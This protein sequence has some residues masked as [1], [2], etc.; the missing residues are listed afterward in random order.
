MYLRGREISVREVK[1]G[2]EP[3][4]IRYISP[5]ELKAGLCSLMKASPTIS[6]VRLFNKLNLLCGNSALSPDDSEL[7]DRLYEELK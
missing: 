4:E 1:R 7:L 5:E 2:D 3:R 6:R